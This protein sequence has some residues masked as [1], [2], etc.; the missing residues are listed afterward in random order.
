MADTR[1]TY[2]PLID[3]VKLIGAVMIIFLHTEVLRSLSSP[4]QTMFRNTVL[5]T[6]VPFFFTASGFFFFKKINAAESGE[7]R[8][9]IFSAAE[10]RIIGLYLIYSAVYLVFVIISWVRNGFT[11]MSVLKYVW[12]FFF[13]GSYSTIW[14]LLALIVATALAYLLYTAWGL[15]VSVIVASVFYLVGTLMSSYCALAQKIP[16]LASA[17]QSYNGL[18]ETVKNGLFFGLIFVL[19]GAVLARKEKKGKISTS[20]LLCAVSFAALVA[21]AVV[22]YKFGWATGGVDLKIMLVPFTYFLF[23]FLFRL[24]DKYN[25]DKFLSSHEKLWKHFRKLSTLMF[26]T[27]RIP[28]SI[29]ELTGISGMN[30]IVYTALVLA[31]TLV[32]SEIII[33]ASEKVHFMKY[34]Y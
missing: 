25:S 23:I 5:T 20:L 34:L 6:A 12:R 27:Q 8:V 24:G 22:Q 21:E 9:K 28:I 2:Y 18:F 1:K 16:F 15:K 31:S 4:L 10:K 32:I 7:K 30:T 11:A 29:F 19:L 33:F 13:V 14:Y 17:I 26:L 3:I